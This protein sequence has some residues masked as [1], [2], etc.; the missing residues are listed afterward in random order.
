MLLVVRD[1]LAALS[2]KRLLQ[3]GRHEHDVVEQVDGPQSAV[4]LIIKHFHGSLLVPHQK[5][6][7][8]SQIRVPL[9]VSNHQISVFTGRYIDVEL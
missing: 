6:V 7:K 5:A 9:L 2:N 3:M 8:H 1:E 4:L